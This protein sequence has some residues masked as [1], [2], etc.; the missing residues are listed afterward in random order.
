EEHRRARDPLALAAASLACALVPWNVALWWQRSRLRLAVEMDCDAR[1]LRRASDVHGYGLLLVDIAQRFDASALTP[2][3]A[4]SEPAS[5]R[6]RKTT[7]M[8]TRPSRHPLTLTALG[9]GALAA[10]V[11]ACTAP[12][13]TNA[14]NRQW[15]LP[16]G[17]NDNRSAGT[18]FE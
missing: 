15:V 8:T 5:S 17:A 10:I 4:L 13:P 2:A 7:A 6:E 3:A 9:V 18:T 1:V 11:F 14:A 12:A 16:D